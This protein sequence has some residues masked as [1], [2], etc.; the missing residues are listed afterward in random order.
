MQKFLKIHFRVI[1]YAALLLLNLILWAIPSNL[2]KLSVKGKPIFLSMYSLEKLTFLFFMIPI[3]GL[4]IYL[5]S[6]TGKSIKKRVFAV[7]VIVMITVPGL[8]LVDLCLRFIKPARYV[9]TD[10][11]YH[12]PPSISYTLTV[13]DKPKSGKSLPI[14]IEPGFPDSECTLTTDKKGFRNKKVQEKY[15]IVV[16]GDSFTEGS[17]VTDD[18]IW[19][20]VLSQKSGYSVYNLGMSGTD[21]LDYFLTLKQFGMEFSPKI[22]ICTIYQG[23]DFRDNGIPADRIRTMEISHSK[24]GK[25]IIK[26]RPIPFKKKIRKYR[27]DSPLLRGFRKLFSKYLII[28]KTQEDS[29]NS[30][31]KVADKKTENKILSW[32]PMK[33]PATDNSK[34]YFFKSKRMLPLWQSKKELL[35]SAG[36]KNCAASLTKIKEFCTKNN[37]RM[38]VTMA[39]LKPTIIF[40]LL[41]K[42]KLPVSDMHA[43]ATLASKR[44]PEKDK[45]I[46]TIYTNLPNQE[47]AL[48]EFCKTNN[49]EYVSTTKALRESMNNGNQ[50]YFTYDQHWSP[51]GHKVVAE[52]I[53]EYLSLTKK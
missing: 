26:E 10:Q 25:A 2:I 23:N 41:K 8:F 15:D 20:H 3:S 46:E 16:I 53:A 21:P 52:T 42:T 31:G 24:S 38:I 45:F 22:V 36:W 11:V 13:K 30:K 5:I 39:Q 40:P 33:I 50:V 44:V 32:L 6:A 49:V 1:L 48:Q 28:E 37:I 7:I 19:P 43:F 14:T 34:Y 35:D 27:K 47:N 4:L 29:K 18:E 51:P 12:R 17:D 9:K